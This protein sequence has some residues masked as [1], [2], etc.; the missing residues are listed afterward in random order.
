M[1]VAHSMLIVLHHLSSLSSSCWLGSLDFTS[2]G[3]FKL[4]FSNF[5]CTLVL[6]GGPGSATTGSTSVAS[7]ELSVVGSSLAASWGSAT[8]AETSTILLS[9]RSIVAVMGLLILDDSETLL[10]LV[11]FS[12]VVVGATVSATATSFVSAEALFAFLAFLAVVMMLMTL[13]IGMVGVVVTVSM[14]FCLVSVFLA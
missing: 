13:T 6:F 7:A 5:S 3:S 2:S 1:K 14:L 9:P 12:E 10:I 11:V 8:T 4:G